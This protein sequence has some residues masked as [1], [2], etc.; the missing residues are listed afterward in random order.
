MNTKTINQ[1]DKK[2]QLYATANDMS[3]GNRLELCPLIN[4]HLSNAIDL[5]MQLKHAHWNVKGSNFIAL[6]ELFDNI[7]EVME[8][9]VDKIAERIVQLGGIAHG[10]VQSVALSSRL[11]EYPYAIADGTLHVAAVTVALSTFGSQIRSMIN[12]AVEL[13]DPAT[14]DLFT[15]VLRGVDKSLWFVEAHQ[16]SNSVEHTI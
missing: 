9:Y 4:N 11:D 7:H 14:V 8:D 12:E 5:Q 16:Q 3:Q 2:I 10:T 13:D 6:H 15:E 1:Q